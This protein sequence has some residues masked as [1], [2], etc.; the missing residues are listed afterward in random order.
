[1]LIDDFFA[2]IRSKHLSVYVPKFIWDATQSGK[3]QF[4]GTG[5]ASWR[6]K[7][8]GFNN[9]ATANLPIPD[10]TDSHLWWNCFKLVWPRWQEMNPRYAGRWPIATVAHDGEG[11]DLTKVRLFFTKDGEMLDR[12]IDHGEVVLCL[13]RYSPAEVLKTQ[14][15]VRDYVTKNPADAIRAAKFLNLK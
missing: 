5:L 1:M 15:R 12:N 6:L 13:R 3:M 9:I 7:Q 11:F 2:T 8:L 4:A 10:F 14:R